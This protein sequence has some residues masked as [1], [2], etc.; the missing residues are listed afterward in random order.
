MT[1]GL[2]TEA[3]RIRPNI[4]RCPL[5]VDLFPVWIKPILTETNDEG[6][7]LSIYHI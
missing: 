4:N 3:C 2:N 5:W 1:D 7:H 6:L